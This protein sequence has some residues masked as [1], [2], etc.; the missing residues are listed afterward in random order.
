[1]MT[2]GTSK[3]HC[4]GLSFSLVKSQFFPRFSL[5]ARHIDHLNLFTLHLPPCQIGFTKK[6]KPSAHKQN[7]LDLLETGHLKEYFLILAERKTLRS[8]G[9]KQLCPHS[10][11]RNLVRNQAT[12]ELCIM[13]SKTGGS[14]ALFFETGDE[15]R[16]Q[17]ENCTGKKPDQT[18]VFT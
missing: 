10:L 9:G 17:D 15:M 13:Y 11:V 4:G 14:G 16:S 8:S 2:P 6:Q 3:A 18:C 1:M 5:K 7:T 12:V